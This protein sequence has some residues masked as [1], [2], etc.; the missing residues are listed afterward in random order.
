RFLPTALCFFLAGMLA[1]RLYARM[2]RRPRLDWLTGLALIAALFAYRPV[3][4]LLEHAGLSPEIARWS[5]YEFAF[6]AMPALFA[7][8]HRSRFDRFLGDFSYAVYLVHWP[9][10]VLIDAVKPALDHD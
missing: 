3:A 6:I 9:V 2:K 5:F 7:S 8:T 4:Q 1:Y 10:L